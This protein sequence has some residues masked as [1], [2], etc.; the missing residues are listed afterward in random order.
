MVAVM[1]QAITWS[2]GDQD[3]AIL[4]HI[5][6]YV[7]THINSKMQTWDPLLELFSQITHEWC[8]TNHK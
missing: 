1:P 6:N 5:I 4:C 2:N 8:H 7:L 3:F